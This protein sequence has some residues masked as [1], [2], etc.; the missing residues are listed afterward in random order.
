MRRFVFVL[1]ALLSAAPWAHAQPS[2]VPPEPCARPKARPSRT[3]CSRARAGRART[4]VTEFEGRYRR[5]SLS[6][7][8]LAL[9]A[10]GFVLTG[11]R[12]TSSTETTLDHIG[13]APVVSTSSGRH[14]TKPLPP[15]V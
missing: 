15:S 8:Q 12:R 1:A 10:A 11:T 6:H 2:G 3:S 7:Y 13:P 14:A 5:G 4:V 9:R